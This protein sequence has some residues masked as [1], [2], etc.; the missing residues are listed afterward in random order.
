MILH[1]ELPILGNHVLMGTDAPK[2]MGFSVIQGNSM[3]IN[4]EPDSREESRRLFDVLSE[5]GQIEMPLQEMFW[6]SYFGSFTYKFGIKW[7]VNH[8]YE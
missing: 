4:L 6:G 3:H 2:E 5:G 1:I 8:Q 7:M